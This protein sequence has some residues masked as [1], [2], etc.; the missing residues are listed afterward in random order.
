MLFDL[1]LHPITEI[2]TGSGNDRPSSLPKTEASNAKSLKNLSNRP[3]TTATG[4]A[5]VFGLLVSSIDAD[6]SATL[7]MHRYPY[8]GVVTS[9]PASAA[10][11]VTGISAGLPSFKTTIVIVPSIASSSSALKTW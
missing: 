7:K 11:S 4:F 5:F 6:S 2:R 9:S 3:V 8:T 1:E 10:R